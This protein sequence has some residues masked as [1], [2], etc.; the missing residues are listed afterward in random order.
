MLGAMPIRSSPQVALRRGPFT[1][2]DARRAGVRWDRLQ[3]K[4]WTRL[5]RGQYAWVGLPQ[6]ARLKLE[7]VARRVP[8]EYAFSGL[9]AAWLHGL[10]IGWTEPI[11]VTVGRDVPIRAR[12]GVRLRRAALS[13]PDVVTR[14]GFRTTSAMRTVCDLGS[15]VDAVASVV[16]VDMA[17]HAGL[18]QLSELA[19]HVVTHA[20]DKGIKRLRRSVLLADPRSE[21]PMETR[22]R[23]ELIRAR[24][25]RP[26][27]QAELRDAT[28]QF[29]GRAD[30]YYPDR[31]LVIE[32]D[33]E[34]HKDRLVADL[35]RQN[36]LVNAGYHI[37]RFT[38]ADL[39]EPGSVAAH[40]RRARALLA[41]VPGWSGRSDVKSGAK[42]G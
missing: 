38:I 27:V 1:V 14:Q 3:T 8:A 36:A 10:G 12:A 42:P 19:T 34:N 18:V 9:T 6:D 35:R 5:S 26:C 20:G 22:V 30:L 2:A 32:Y 15:R 13:E 17:L 37:L 28:G 4:M 23:M 11:E 16:A 31:R 25:P 41:Q 33:G 24:L 7:A 29:L 21:S 40:V 39:R